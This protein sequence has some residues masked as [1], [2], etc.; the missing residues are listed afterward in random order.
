MP[1]SRLTAE[2]VC[3]RLKI[4]EPV[5]VTNELSAREKQILDTKL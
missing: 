4:L 5:A 3:N 2:S 1:V